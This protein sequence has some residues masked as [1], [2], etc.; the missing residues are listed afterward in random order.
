MS[1]RRNAYM[2]RYRAEVM[3]I[4]KPRHEFISPECCRDCQREY[5][6]ESTRRWRERIKG[7]IENT[8]REGEG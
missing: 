5:K 7:A 4:V 1:A 8:R 2:R 3:A 6:R